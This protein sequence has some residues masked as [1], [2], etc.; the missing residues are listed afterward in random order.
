M[1][2]KFRAIKPTK[3]IVQL[4]VLESHLA[5]ELNSF[6]TAVEDRMATYPRQ[7]P[8]KSGYRRTGTLMRSWSV[9]RA[10]MRGGALVAQVGSNANIAPYNELV[11]GERQTREMRRRG[12]PRVM[13]VAKELWPSVEARIRRI[14]AEAG[15]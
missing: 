1:P 14:L 8:T 12:W 4:A 10:R 15:T 6:V 7:Q 5:A 2:V 13:D 3:P 11:E 9:V